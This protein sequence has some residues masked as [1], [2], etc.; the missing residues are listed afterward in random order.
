MRTDATGRIKATK[1]VHNAN[2]EIDASGHYESFV[3]H[4]MRENRGTVVATATATA[5]ATTTT[6]TT[7]NEGIQRLT[8]DRERGGVKGGR[9]RLGRDRTKLCIR[10]R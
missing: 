10:R 1:S 6:A 9:A 2:D 5:T 8:E 7:N 3:T 4:L